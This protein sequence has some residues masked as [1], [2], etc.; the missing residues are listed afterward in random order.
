[1]CTASV[2]TGVRFTVIDVNRTGISLHT[3]TSV[4]V[5]QVRTTKIKI[6]IKF[7]LFKLRLTRAVLVFATEHK[8][9]VD[10]RLRSQKKVFFAK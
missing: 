8:N 5:K 1:M 9:N 6:Q 4:V 10:P 2:D 7:T 3:V